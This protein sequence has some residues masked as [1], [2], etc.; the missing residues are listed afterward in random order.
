MNRPRDC[1]EKFVF[2]TSV[3][4]ETTGAHRRRVFG[5]IVVSLEGV[6][7]N[8]LLDRALAEE[9]NPTEQTANNRDERPLRKR[10][11]SR[12]EREIKIMGKNI[13]EINATGNTRLRY[14]G[15]TRI[16]RCALFLVPRA[17]RLR[18]D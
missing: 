13:L 7:A 9:R 11:P 14:S 2:S 18:E 17:L 16:V 4:R 5:G 6:F 12:F 1:S 8:E 15:R 3:I 10:D